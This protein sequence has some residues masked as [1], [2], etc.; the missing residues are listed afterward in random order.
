MPRAARSDIDTLRQEAQAIELL[1]SEAD[2]AADKLEEYWN[3]S[4]DLIA[5]VTDIEEYRSEQPHAGYDD[6]V[7][8]TFKQRLR[9][10]V[11]RLAEMT[12]R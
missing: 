9:A 11:S 8:F 3:L 12:P 7:M 2:I 10:I 4:A 1:A 5:L 6:P